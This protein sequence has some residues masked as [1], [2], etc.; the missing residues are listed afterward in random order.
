MCVQLLLVINVAYTLGQGRDTD[1]EVA[2]HAPGTQFM[3]N[4]ALQR[5]RG[6][7]GLGVRLKDARCRPDVVRLGA[8]PQ[9][10]K[11]LDGLVH[12]GPGVRGEVCGVERPRGDPDDPVIVGEAVHALV[13]NALKHAHLESTPRATTTKA[14]DATWG[15][16]LFGGLSE[17]RPAGQREEGKWPHSE[18][19]A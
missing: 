17:P 18:G 6:E 7:E 16:G 9:I 12:L 15:K 10:G 1:G 2:L 11:G 13:G 14:E 4:H 3:P 8:S 19:V 5:R